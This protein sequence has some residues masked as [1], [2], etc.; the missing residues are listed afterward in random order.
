M[1][2]LGGGGASCASSSSVGFL[3]LVL[4]SLPPHSLQL[5]G[6]GGVAGPSITRRA[7]GG[8]PGTRLVEG[9]LLHTMTTLTPPP[10]PFR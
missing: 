2:V 10:L 5:C 3:G 7:N 6:L 4:P 1:D 8:E 9:Q